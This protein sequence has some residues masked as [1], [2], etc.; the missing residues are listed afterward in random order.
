[1]PTTNF[2]LISSCG[3]C[4]TISSIANSNDGSYLHNYHYNITPTSVRQQST[5]IA[6]YFTGSNTGSTVQHPPLVAHSKYC[7]T[8]QPLPPSLLAL[9]H[10]AL[11]SQ[12]SFSL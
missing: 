11:V 1:M 8:L 6:S 12:Y 5:T 7:T 9:K 2:S 10:Y 4:H 3:S